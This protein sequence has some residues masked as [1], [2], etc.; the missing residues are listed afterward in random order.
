MSPRSPPLPAGRRF[1]DTVRGGG[2]QQPSRRRQSP[3]ALAESVC[4]A[5]H[6]KGSETTVRELGPTLAAGLL[7]TF[8]SRENSS[9]TRGNLKHLTFQFQSFPVPEEML[10]GPLA[11]QDQRWRS[12]GTVRSGVTEATGWRCLAKEGP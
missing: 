2:A 7:W 10:W 12:L 11:T 4:G 6:Q 8:P 9:L 5:R 3:G 1:L